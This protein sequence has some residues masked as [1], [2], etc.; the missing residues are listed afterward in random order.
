MSRGG[1]RSFNKTIHYYEPY[2]NE[3]RHKVG[4][5]MRVDFRPDED[6]TF[7]TDHFKKDA[8]TKESVE[9]SFK[10]LAELYEWIDEQ[11]EVIPEIVWESKI[12]V[13]VRGYS[14]GKTNPKHTTW[15]GLSI[16]HSS[17]DI[18]A[19]AVEIGTTPDGRKWRRCPGE[20]RVSKFTEQIGYGLERRYSSDKDGSPYSRA[21][22]DDTPQNREMLVAFAVKFDELRDQF[23]KAFA[24][25][26]VHRFL[27]QTAGTLLLNAPI[28][29]DEVTTT[30]Q[31]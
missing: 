10:T 1:D 22:I 25:E 4:I 29:G 26:Y 2:I 7:Y 15:K 24:P 19:E 18:S 28:A 31:T 21:L 14:Y 13:E 20:K 16:S 12:F 27:S 23:F 9:N 30:N 6:V 11:L 8:D 3:K 5:K 17:L